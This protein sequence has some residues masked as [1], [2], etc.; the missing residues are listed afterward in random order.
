MAVTGGPDDPREP[1]PNTLRRPKIIV[2]RGLPGA[3]KST[4][5]REYMRTHP[6]QAGVV[7]RD[8]IRQ[9]VLG[10]SM[11][12]GDAVLDR[13]GEDLVTA[14]IEATARCLLASGRTVIAD[15]THLR[16]DHIDSWRVLSAEYGVPVEVV[17]LDVPAEECIR[18]DAARAAAGGR[19]V[20]ADV[21]HAMADGRMVAGQSMSAT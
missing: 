2:L 15:A 11:T 17:D 16:A 18:R 3:G 10:L 20:G 12:P 7:S 4:R 5:A 8:T 21:I 14:I 9:H 6:G 13:A 1:W 19:G